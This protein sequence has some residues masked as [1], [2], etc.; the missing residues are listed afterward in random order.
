MSQW[1]S[2]QQIDGRFI[3]V[4]L[5]PDA[6]IGRSM[7]FVLFGSSLFAYWEPGTYRECLISEIKREFFQ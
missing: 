1:V 4:T 6:P 2:L 3:G 5:I 7:P